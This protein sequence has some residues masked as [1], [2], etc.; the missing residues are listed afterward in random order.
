MFSRLFTLGFYLNPLPNPDFQ[1][2]KLTLTLCLLLI[3]GGIGLYYYRTKQLKEKKL[4][5]LLKP[6]SG[7][8]I[9]YGF[10][11]LAL[12]FFRET[13]LPYLSM[14]LWWVVLLGFMIYSLVRFL[15]MYSAKDKGFQVKEKKAKPTDKYLPKRKK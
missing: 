14:R 4:K 7:K 2:S 5:K 8:L 12:L 13:G 9:N 10:I 11:A 3:L 6:Y 15:Q 1:Y